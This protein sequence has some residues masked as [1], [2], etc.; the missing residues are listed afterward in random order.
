VTEVRYSVPDISC[1]HCV[2][3]IST[4]VEKVPGVVDVLVN[5]ETKLVTVSG[6]TLDDLALREAIDEAGYDVAG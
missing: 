5:V 3:A 6:E 4:E 1:E 2:N